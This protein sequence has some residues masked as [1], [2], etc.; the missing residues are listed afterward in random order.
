MYPDQPMFFSHLF[1]AIPSTFADSEHI[2][3]LLNLNSTTIPFILALLPKL[4]KSPKELEYCLFILGNYCMSAIFIVFSWRFLGACYKKSANQLFYGNEALYMELLKLPEG[5]LPQR[6][7][8][9]H[10]HNHAPS[11]FP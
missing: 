10:F 6:V 8:F 11:F 3:D 5:P 4:S 9:F 7:C 1:T 2:A